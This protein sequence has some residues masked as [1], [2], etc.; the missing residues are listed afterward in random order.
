MARLTAIGSRLSP[1]RG[2]LG[3]VATGAAGEDRRDAMI[4]GRAWYH[5]AEWRRLRAGVLRDALY[6]CAMCGRVAPSAGLVADHV[7]P[8]RWD[9]DLFFLRSNLQCLCKA[10]HDGAKQRSERKGGVG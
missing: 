8:H 7:K 2:R 10:C 9:R 1:L 6:T 3:T 4:A 5:T